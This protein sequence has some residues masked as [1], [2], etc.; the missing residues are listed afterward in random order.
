MKSTEDHLREMLS[1]R[2]DRVRPGPVPEELA[3]EA[4]RPDRRFP[5]PALLAAAAVVVVVAVAAL[6]P[7]IGR[8]DGDGHPA[9]AAT[10]SS[11]ATQLPHR[12]TGKLPA[13]SR[14]PAAG[15]C[16]RVAS[17]VVTV[18]IEPDVPVPRCSMVR[19]DQSLRVVNRTGDYGQRAHPVRVRWVPGQPVR[20]T[21]GESH[22]FPRRFGDYLERG[23]HELR[24]TRAYTAEIWLR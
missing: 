4:A 14:Y 12:G 8:G 5:V 1:E 10:S 13:T 24:I 18:R 17:S 9:P 15:V 3:R 22:T 6:V 19:A 23:V 11:G 2:A 20:L 16:G 7:L 21:P